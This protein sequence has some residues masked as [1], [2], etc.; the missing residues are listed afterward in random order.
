[1]ASAA[2]TKIHIAMLGPSLF[3]QGGMATV[4][5][6]IVY[7]SSDDLAIRHITT[8]DEGSTCYRIRVFIQGLLQF[9]FLF[10]RWRVD[11]VHLHVSERG[12]VWRMGVLVLFS[13]LLQRPVVMH[14]HGS[15][16]HQFFAN[17]SPVGQRWVRWIFQCCDTVI[18]LSN[19]WRQ[20]YIQNCRLA[21]DRVV[22]MLNPVK[23][24]AQLPDRRQSQPIKFIFLGRIGERKG[25]FDV[26]QAVAQIPATQR[27]QLQVWLVGDGEVAQAQALIEQHQL[28]GQVQLLGW[29]D[30]V[31]RDRLLSQA[32]VFLLPSHN[33]GLPVAMLE[34]MAWGLPVIVTPVGGIPELIINQKHGFLVS[35]GKVEEIQQAMQTLLSDPQQRW[36]MGAAAREAITPLDVTQYHQSLLQLYHRLLPRRTGLQSAIAPLSPRYREET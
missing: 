29:I 26:I 22:V 6:L 2:M 7:Q 19:S 23:I 8:H 28:Q 35:P 5:N 4:E 15:E 13:R 34:A 21:P 33:E 31:T 3:Q 27:Q 12:S 16:F 36:T 24:P 18:T 14:T 9:F 10:L 17:L 20:Y 11:L 32:D 25:A 1:M 30:A